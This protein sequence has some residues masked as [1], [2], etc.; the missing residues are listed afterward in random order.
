MKWQMDS[1]PQN[2]EHPLS[3]FGINSSFAAAQSPTEMNATLRELQILSKCQTA[4]KSLCHLHLNQSIKNKHKSAQWQHT[5]S[6]LTFKIVFIHI[7]FTSQ[8][9]SFSASYSHDYA[10][11]S[12]QS[13]GTRD[14]GIP[15]PQLSRRFG[16]DSYSQSPPDTLNLSLSRLSFS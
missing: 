4:M 5:I 2:Y 12:V 1:L 3:Q 9:E 10:Y 15:P 8:T 16:R 11:D 13:S 14:H 6:L 7:Y